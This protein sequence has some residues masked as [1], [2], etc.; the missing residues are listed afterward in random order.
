MILINF[1]KSED[2]N[3]SMTDDEERVYIMVCNILV[4]EYLKTR[5]GTSGE[6]KKIARWKIP[7]TGR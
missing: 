4:G 2:R 7:K 1:D 6:E 3:T 5:L